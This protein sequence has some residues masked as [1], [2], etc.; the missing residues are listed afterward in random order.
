MGSADPYFGNKQQVCVIE[1]RKQKLRQEP[2]LYRTT[3]LGQAM[4]HSHHRAASTFFSCVSSFA[5]Q[6]DIILLVGIFVFR[7]TTN[8]DLADSSFQISSQGS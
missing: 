1:V 4:P 5:V 8:M 3:A 7:D 2:T 6:S